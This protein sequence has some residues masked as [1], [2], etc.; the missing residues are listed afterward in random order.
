MVNDK[1]YEEY[2][3][4]MKRAKHF[5]DIDLGMR[6]HEMVRVHLAFAKEIREGGDAWG[7]WLTEDDKSY[8]I[9]TK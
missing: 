9:K 6:F 4:H 5:L 2:S 1:V 8:R 7:D 3:H